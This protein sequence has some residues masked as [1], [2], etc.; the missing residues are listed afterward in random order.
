MLDET[1]DWR[2]YQREI[3]ATVLFPCAQGTLDVRCEVG[4]RPTHF[5]AVDQYSPARDRAH[6][7]AEVQR[8][9]PDAL[10]LTCAVIP[11]AQS[12]FSGSLRF[13]PTQ[14]QRTGMR[15]QHV[16]VRAP[17]AAEDT[18]LHLVGRAGEGQESTTAADRQRGQRRWYVP[19]AFL[20]DD[21]R[22]LRPS[23]PE[24]RVEPVIEIVD[25][26]TLTVAC[27]SASTEIGMP[28]YEALGRAAPRQTYHSLAWPSGTQAC[29]LLPEPILPAR[30][31]HLAP[32]YEE[33]WNMLLR[34]V[35]EP[36]P[37]SGLPNSYVSTGSNFPDHL[38]VWDSCFTTLCLAYGHRALPAT[39]LLDVLYS[40]Q[41]DGGYIHR[42]HNVHDGLPA[43]FEPGFSPN[44]PL[45]S[46]AEWKLAALSGTGE[47][48]VQVYPVLCGYHRWIEANRRLPDGTYWTT[49]LASGL[50]NSPAH[51][52]GYPCLT[53]QMAHDAEVL[54]HIA[55]LLGR[56]EEARAWAEEHQKTG[57]ALNRALWD[58]DVCIYA[59]SLPGGGHSP[60]KVVTAFWP[61]WAGVVPP[62][63]V[64]ALLAHLQDPRS[65]CRHHPLP[66][67]AADS[68]CFHPAGEY[69][70]GS[71]WAPT[72]YA[73]IKG[74]QRAGRP[75][76]AAALTAQHLQCVFEVW[77]CTGKLWEN[78]SSEQSVPGNH[79]A[80]DYCWSALGPI[81]LLFEVLLGL[82]PNAIGQTLRWQPAEDERVGVKRFPL[83]PATISLLQQPRADGRWIEIMTD[84]PFTLEL[85]HQGTL[86]RIA[87][88]PGFTELLL[89]PGREEA[90]VELAIKRDA[91][92]AFRSD[93]IAD[94]LRP[95]TRRPGEEPAIE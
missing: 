86:Q 62:E 8:L 54:G 30:L 48:L 90:I 9:R 56:Q 77:S 18:S 69:W 47:R 12:G 58:E 20:Q 91:Q 55:R 25:T 93:A 81:A 67:L 2:S 43:L 28:R 51:G 74:L 92:A 32:L 87:C 79:S 39:A 82:E 50:D 80:P 44:P 27:A 52:D 24:A 26:I 65:F 49:G 46:T 75:D 66:S 16:L 61:L 21:P 6:V 35:R 7:L 63:R 72:N 33:A 1:L 36:S 4:E 88:Q 29:S 5:L 15:W 22:P 31:A 94:P 38:F 3:R 53:A 64:A 59:T 14:F 95:Q 85:V 76:L 71:T 17:A 10:A 68:P 78:Y 19:V 83:G 42:E 60:H 23:G 13:L 57:E 84:S 73:A 45:L 11:G 41:F 40:R 89:V 37:A 70:Q 34:L